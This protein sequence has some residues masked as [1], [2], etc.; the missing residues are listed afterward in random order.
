MMNYLNKLHQALLS[1]NSTQPILINNHHHHQKSNHSIGTATPLVGPSRHHHHHHHHGTTKRASVAIIIRIKPDSSSTTTTSS[2]SSSPSSSTSSINSTPDQNPSLN[3]IQQTQLKPNLSIPIHQ[4]N[5]TQNLTSTLNESFSNPCLQSSSTPEILFIKRSSRSNDRWSSHLAFPGGRMEPEDEDT[6][7]CALRET[8]EEVGIDLAEED[9]LLIGQLDDREITTSLGKRLLMIL[10]SFV[11]L[12][13]KPS[14]D[15][16]DPKLEID[17]DEVASAYWVPID[18][19]LGHQVRWGE[20]EI[21]VSTR[22]LPTKHSFIKSILS[23]LLGNMKFPSIL[24][25]DHPSIVASSPNSP[26]RTYHETSKNPKPDLDLWGITL[27]ITLDL[28]SFIADPQFAS[29]GR[30]HQKPINHQSS[31]A[32]ST[33]ILTPNS[34]PSLFRSPSISRLDHL[35]APPDEMTISAPSITS[36]FPRF[37]YPDVNALIWLLGGRY[38]NLLRSWQPA[39]Q[40]HPRSRSTLALTAFYTAVRKALMVAVILRFLSLIGFLV[41]VFKRLSRSRTRVW[42]IV[43]RLLKLIKPIN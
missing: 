42:M 7:F 39:H 35:N 31:I 5:P 11:Y 38:R 20:V 24:L 8:F 34:T 32:T 3:F 2:S 37:T 43:S 21:N 30:H 18:Q 41:F 13:T 36:I 23:V 12:Y 16:H 26:S 17:S 40:R 33:P 15:D 29:T 25:K 27:G 6:Q 28:M 4:S 9:Y 1:I 14:Q 10:S 19:L 22:I